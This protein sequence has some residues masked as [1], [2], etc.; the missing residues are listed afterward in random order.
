M[1]TQFREMMSFRQ[2]DAPGGG[3]SYKLRYAS[4]Q[5]C[6]KVW[7]TKQKSKKHK[8]IA[9]N[10][11]LEYDDIGRAFLIKRDGRVRFTIDQDDLVTLM[12]D[13]VS[14]SA[15]FPVMSD[16]LGAIVRSEKSVLKSAKFQIHANPMGEVWYDKAAEF[17]PLQAGTKMKY[18]EIIYNPA[19]KIRSINKERVKPYREKIAEWKKIL[20]TMTA[21]SYEE[22]MKS[23]H[24]NDRWKAHQFK[25]P[26]FEDE[27][28]ADYAKKLLDRSML[29]T[30]LHMSYEDRINGVV[31]PNFQKNLINKI[32][33]E[34]REAWYAKHEVYDWSFEDE[35]A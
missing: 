28:T 10:T 34:M 27:I 16:V 6:Q 14:S 33:E 8:R 12:S 24:V 9:A 18:G 2:S 20:L 5:W 22:L 1:I 35:V 13:E 21:I 11:F 17:A 29:S 4:W 25:I 31:S 19:V 26:K 15:D 30:Q 3:R 32:I 7:D 23:K